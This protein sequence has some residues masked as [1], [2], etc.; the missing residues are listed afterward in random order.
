MTS[1]DLTLYRCYHFCAARRLTQLDE[2]HCC[3]RL[4]GH[5]F[6]LV[7]TLAGALDPHK[8]WLMDFAQ[9]DAIIHPIIAQCDHRYLNDIPQ[10]ENP[11]TENIA[12][13][14][15]RAIQKELPL[16]Q[17]LTLEEAAEQGVTLTAQSTSKHNGAPHANS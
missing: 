13:W 15:W 16:L 6:R 11:T 17:K 10:L 14:L 5:N 3:S 8:G 4:H 9:L 12:L 2:T 1:P 7:I